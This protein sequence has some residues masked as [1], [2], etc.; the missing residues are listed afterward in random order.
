M[1]GSDGF[2]ELRKRLELSEDDRLELEQ[3]VRCVSWTQRIWPRQ[4]TPV[5]S[6]ECSAWPHARDRV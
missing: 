1:E 6:A 5:S 2:G 4:A 3:I